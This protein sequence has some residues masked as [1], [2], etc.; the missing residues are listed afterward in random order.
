MSI[1]SE[2]E[3]KA[4]RRIGRIVARAL[5]EMMR[6][7]RQG[8]TTGELD[9][10]GAKALAEYGARS[11]PRLA[12]DFPGATCI[13]VNDEAA[14]GIP[15]SRVIQ[16]GDLVNID[17][18]AELDGYFADTGASVAIPPVSPLKRKLC[19]CT[20]SALEQA[21]DAAKAGQPMNVI[22]RTVEREARRCGFTVIRELG[23]HG[24]GR[25]IHEDP[26]S[27]LNYYA[28]WNNQRLKEGL[29]ITIEPFLSLGSSAVHTDEDGW[30]LRTSNGS[31]VA[32]YEHTLV[33][34]S[35]APIVVT[36][37]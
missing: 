33:I 32:Q 35:G 10:V 14:H 8:M 11:A 18:S 31:L 37:A 12:Y 7:V 20:Q 13:S 30:T 24:V 26:H 34:T 5:E 9:D 1:E 36:T 22:G 23:G 16:A 21:M 29:V 28:P 17:V 3:L 15:G 27:V 25:H 2:E 4:L 6:H 19:R